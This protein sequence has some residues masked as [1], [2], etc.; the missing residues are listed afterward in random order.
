MKDEKTAS[1]D[2]S[3]I[4]HISSFDSS[5]ASIATRFALFA[6]DLAAAPWLGHGRI[7]FRVVSLLLLSVVRER[8]DHIEQTRRVAYRGKESES[9]RRDCACVLYGAVKWPPAGTSI[10]LI[11]RGDEF[12]PENA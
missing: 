10:A 5:F 12:L 9:S 3:F 1:P 6:A 11:H 7:S 2:S 4:L 8:F